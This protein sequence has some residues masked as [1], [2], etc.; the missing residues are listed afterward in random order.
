LTETD[1]EALS[2][3]NQAILAEMQDLNKAKPS[4]GA[5]NN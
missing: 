1:K 3:F 5:D 2:Q 4:L